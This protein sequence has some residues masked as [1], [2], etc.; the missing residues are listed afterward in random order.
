MYNCRQCHVHFNLPSLH[1][2]ITCQHSLVIA[3][4]SIPKLFVYLL[5]MSVIVLLLTYF[6][7]N[8]FSIDSD[9][10][11]FIYFSKAKWSECCWAVEL[12]FIVFKHQIYLYLLNMTVKL[13]YMKSVFS[14]LICTDSSIATAC[15]ISTHITEFKNQI[16][17][18]IY[19][20]KGSH[21]CIILNNKD[22]C[23]I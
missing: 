14:L 1:V 20:H 3:F 17:N 23:L 5:Y 18:Y 7:T 8:Q 4:P 21:T 15:Q 9:V 13:Q 19:V 10:C 11:W 12:I 22:K 16:T 2:P 6:E